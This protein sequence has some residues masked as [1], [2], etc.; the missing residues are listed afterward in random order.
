MPPQIKRFDRAQTVPT[1]A[2]RYD[3][4]PIMLFFRPNIFGLSQPVRGVI[5][6]NRFGTRSS[7]RMG[8]TSGAELKRGH[9]RGKKRRQTTEELAT[10]RRKNP[11][12]DWP[13]YSSGLESFNKPVDLPG[14]GIQAWLG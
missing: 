12:R 7:Q 4:G 5:D 2:K 9:R 6:A 11:F 14:Q 8:G 3:K 1:S 10:E 13:F